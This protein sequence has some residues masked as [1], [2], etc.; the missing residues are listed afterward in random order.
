MRA[1]QIFASL[2]PERTA[3]FFALIAKESPAM[4][5]Q[6]VHATSAALRSRPAYLM[7]QPAE[8]RAAS[9]RRALSRVNADA[10]AAEM[11]AVYFLECRKPLLIEWLDTIG[12]AHSDGSLEEDLPKQPAAAELERGVSGFR[13]ANDDWDRELLM[14]AFAAQDA[15]EWPLLDALLATAAPGS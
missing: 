12:V 8:K 9:M 2:S 4:Y 14:R 7:K 6:L 11:L 5:A 15:I 13:T 3:D 10:L 1:F